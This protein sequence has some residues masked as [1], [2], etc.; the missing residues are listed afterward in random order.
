VKKFG[1]K[2]G[3]GMKTDRYSPQ[4][5]GEGF[6]K[7]GLSLWAIKWFNYCRIIFRWMCEEVRLEGRRRNED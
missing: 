6:G 4:A 1:S 3:G 5:G 7:R 2:G